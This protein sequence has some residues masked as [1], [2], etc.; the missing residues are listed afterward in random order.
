M[1]TAELKSM[2]RQEL[3]DVARDLDIA[4]RSSMT[5]NELVAAIS[6]ARRSE[7]ARQAAKSK[8]AT[9]PK[10]KSS[11]SASS[12][13]TSSG[14]SQDIKMSQTKQSPKKTKGIKAKSSPVAVKAKPAKKGDSAARSAA[15]TKKK[16]AA[17]ATSKPSAAANNTGTKL[18]TKS[19]RAKRSTAKPKTA[20]SKKS[21][22][23]SKPA[24]P[25][26]A[27]SQSGRAAAK[28]AT[29]VAARKSSTA[30]ADKSSASGQFVTAKSQRV[31]DEMRRRSERAMQNKDLSTGVLIAGSAVRGASGQSEQTPHK[32]R[33]SLVVRDSYWLQADWEITR[34]AVDR[35]RVAMSE[36][37]HG[38]QPVLRLMSVGDAAHNRA[39]QL[40]RDIPIHGGVNTWYIDVDDPPARYRVVI[41]YVAQ[42]D[43]F[44]PLCR[45]NIVHTPKA[46]SV[47]RLDRH[48]SDIAEDYERIYSL[49]GGFDPSSGGEIKELFE[50]RLQRPMPSR[51]DDGAGRD[52]DAALD[53]HRALPFEVD[54][55]LIIFGRTIPGATVLLSGEPV[56]LREDGSFTIRV[57]LP[58]KRQVLPVIAQSR[59]STKQ[60][61]TVIAIER[62]TRVMETVDR[63][64]LF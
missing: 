52:T 24:Q 56:K 12:K 44:Y 5:K 2:T 47:H 4:R 61:T 23:A 53:R 21:R 48:W 41:G 3:S 29:K 58:D 28:S 16:S 1:T 7:A 43:R 27:R 64:Q 50:Q 18:A 17:K 62:N 34:A 49:S 57:A 39:E 55:E 46:D 59:D 35:V 31:R 26:S 45:S 42:N 6:S 40:V 13:S 38:A 60:R 19:V 25:K 33:I 20:A 30:A 51:P 54:A 22:A 15:K 36:K 63:D 10:S 9:A 11:K 37:W 32:D 8:Q 14:T